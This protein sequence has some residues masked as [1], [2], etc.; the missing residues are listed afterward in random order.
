MLLLRDRVEV[1]TEFNT[2]FHV[3]CPLNCWPLEK[4]PSTL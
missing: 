4:V 2:V 1:V 3:I